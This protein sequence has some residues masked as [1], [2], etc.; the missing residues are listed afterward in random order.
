MFRIRYTK[1]VHRKKG[2]VVIV[3][4]DAKG[5][6]VK[7]SLLDTTIKWSGD[8]TMYEQVF[9]IKTEKELIKENFTDDAVPLKI[10]ITFMETQK[11]VYTIIPK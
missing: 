4:T 11:K 10:V 5:K 8:G 7:Y 6:P 9:L 3:F 2:G 1:P